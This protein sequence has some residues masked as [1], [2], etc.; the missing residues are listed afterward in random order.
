MQLKRKL[1]AFAALLTAALFFAAAPAK[2]QALVSGGFGSYLSQNQQDTL[3]FA[4]HVT[5]SSSGSVHGWFLFRAPNTTQ[6]VDVTSVMTLPNGAVAFAGPIVW[7]NGTPPQGNVLG[8]TAFL[9]FKD[10]GLGVP[11]ETA[12]YSVV[13]VG[14]PL[15]LTIQQIVGAIGAPPVYRPLS[16][17]NIWIH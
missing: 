11:D 14:F 5:Q 16:T 13:P 15:N 8:R 6:L 1:S 9:A 3:R 7:F 12:G 17:G 2:A 4:Y 10:N